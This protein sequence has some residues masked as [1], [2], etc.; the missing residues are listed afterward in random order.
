VEAVQKN[1]VRL[2]PLLAS[3]PELNQRVTRELRPLLSGERDA[4]AAAR[5]AAS[6]LNQL[7]AGG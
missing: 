2:P 4:G 5:A 6:A 3:W 7:L 1:A